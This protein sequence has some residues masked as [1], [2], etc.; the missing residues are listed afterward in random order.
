[1]MKERKDWIIWVKLFTYCPVTK[2]SQGLRMGKGKGSTKRWICP[3]NVGQIVYELNDPT[4][5]TYRFF[6]FKTFCKVWKK[7]PFETSIRF[8]FH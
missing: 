8:K 7:L 5:I 3:I 6:Y 2:K 4:T 1:M